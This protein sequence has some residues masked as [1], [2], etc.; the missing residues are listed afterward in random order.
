M[1]AVL[2]E[3]LSIITS[4]AQTT[5]HRI[6]GILNEDDCQMVFSDT[7]GVLKPHYAMQESMMKG[8]YTAMEDADI[9][10]FLTEPGD[11]G[12]ADESVEKKLQ[13]T[14]IPLF[15]II[16]KIDTS[17]QKILED[18]IQYWKDKFPLAEIRVISA[19]H[20]HGVKELV[21]EFKA[22]LPESPK[23]FPDESLTDRSE[24]FFVSE[25]VREKILL[26]YSKEVPYSV[27]VEVESFK[28]VEEII[29]MRAIIYVARDSQKGILIGHKGNALKRVGIQARADLESFF[30]K[31]VHLELFVKVSKE[32][33]NSEQQ[34]KRFG[35]EN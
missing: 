30:S 9:L 25:I 2:G 17:E 15:L 27:Q 3:R 29:R 8:V 6:I 34:L 5:R 23:Y 7:P 24:R 21:E 33:R 28:E 12:L 16:N 19:L 1:N 10:V 31:K 35:Y 4:K 22:L 20:G 14:E 26:N 18:T 32:W 13:K 11:K